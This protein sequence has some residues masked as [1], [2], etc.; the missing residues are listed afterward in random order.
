MRLKRKHPAKVAE[1]LAL[2]SCKRRGGNAHGQQANMP[3][4]KERLEVP[5]VQVPRV[6]GPPIHYSHQTRQRRALQLLPTESITS[7]TW[8]RPITHTQSGMCVQTVKSFDVALVKGYVQGADFSSLQRPQK[9]LITDCS[10]PSE[11]HRW[12]SM[13]TCRSFWN[14]V[15]SG[16]CIS[17]N[18]Q[19]P[20][21]PSLWHAATR[22]DCVT[23][24]HWHSAVC[25]QLASDWF[26]QCYLGRLPCRVD[27]SADHATQS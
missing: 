3:R 23:C 14:T 7:P 25:M 22:L 24:T 5:R 20:R 10:T 9:P 16:P 1:M 8:T 2:S 12:K 26:W 17:I 19:V 27:W 18:K 13:E 15:S 4:N 11:V 21:L 6:R